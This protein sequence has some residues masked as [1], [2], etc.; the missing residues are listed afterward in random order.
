MTS[1]ATLEYRYLGSRADWPALKEH[2]TA[3]RF[4]EGEPSLS[5]L[6]SY[7]TCST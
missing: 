3:V 5:L 6:F 2:N 7:E 4:A 1:F